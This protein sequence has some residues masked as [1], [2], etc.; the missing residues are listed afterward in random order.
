MII[1]WSL[2]KALCRH[3]AATSVE[4]GTPPMRSIALAGMVSF[5]DFAFLVA[6]TLLVSGQWSSVVISTA[7]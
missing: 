2:W 3:S 7:S 6:M 5:A 1:S 4:A